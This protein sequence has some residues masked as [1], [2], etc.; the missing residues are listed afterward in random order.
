MSFTILKKFLCWTALRTV[1]L[2]TIWEGFKPGRRDKFRGGR[3][4][5]TSFEGNYD[6]EEYLGKPL[7]DSIYLSF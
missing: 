7:V 1:A 6:G 2:Y 4:T 3:Y 5:L